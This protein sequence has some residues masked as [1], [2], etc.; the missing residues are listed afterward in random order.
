MQNKSANNKDGALPSQPTA[1]TDLDWN[2]PELL[3][4]LDHDRAFFRELLVIFG[5]DI[6]PALLDARATLD[7]QDLPAL[8]RI[9]HTL[10]GMLRN[11]SMNRAAQAAVDLELAARDGSSS[12]AVAAMAQLEQAVAEILPKVDAQIAEVNA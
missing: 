2:L 12:A 5:Q 6:R 9:A 11:L 3:E 4:R 1:S 7:R 10:K 8:Q